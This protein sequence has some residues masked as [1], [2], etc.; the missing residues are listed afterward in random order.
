MNNK[1]KD[2]R[3]WVFG[4]ANIDISGRAINPLVEYDSNIGHISFCHGG[5]GRNIAQ[6]ISLTLGDDGQVYFVTAFSGDEFGKLLKDDCKAL[7]INCDYSID[8]DDYP[9]SIYLALM[10]HKGDMKI[11][12]S[13][14]EILDVFN[15]EI[16]EGVL[17]NV[18]EKDIIVTDLNLPKELLDV[19]IG[20]S[21][22][23]VAVDP[24]SIAKIKKVPD[25][26][27]KIDIFKPNKIEAEYL[28]S[29]SITDETSAKESLKWFMDRGVK[30]IILTLGEKGV[31][32]GLKDREE[33][34]WFTHREID[35]KNATG[36]GDTFLGAYIAV[37]SMGYSEI[38][39]VEYAIGAAISTIETH[40]SVCKHI[41]RE[42]LREVIE[43]ASI[44]YTKL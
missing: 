6:A 28:N 2:N 43:S 22:C 33:Y 8:T 20:E 23:R 16:L 40:E 37:R 11:A 27:A 26:L 21:P 13:D 24:I 29:I 35:L 41:S 39:A 32:L 5:V 34:Y 7:G 14:M 19:I 1:N 9:T 25:F 44:E 15:K 42:T 3:I 18:S 17:S 12:M 38:D 31:L 30:E 36:G 4:G 10:D